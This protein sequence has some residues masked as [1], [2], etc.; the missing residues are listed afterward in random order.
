M[1]YMPRNVPVKTPLKVLI[2]TE[3]VNEMDEIIKEEAFNGRT[4]LI[5]YLLRGY[6]EKHKH[7]KCIAQE[8]QVYCKKQEKK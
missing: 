6:I 3:L 8:Y 2:Q 4:D 5:V 1:Q 7:Q